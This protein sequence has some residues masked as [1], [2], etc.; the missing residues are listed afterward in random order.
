MAPSFYKSNKKE[1]R[2]F[3]ERARIAPAKKKTDSE[4][5]VKEL[6]NRLSFEQLRIL[7][8]KHNIA[9]KSTVE[10]GLFETRNMEPTKYQYVEKLL[11]VVSAEEIRALPAKP[12]ALKKNRR[13]ANNPW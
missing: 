10:K 4:L 5:T 9:I 3:T 1:N 2:F 6:L 7:A 11:D 12:K 13:Q 8:L